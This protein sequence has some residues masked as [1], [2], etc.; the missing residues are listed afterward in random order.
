MSAARSRNAGMRSTTTAMKRD[1]A[2]SVRH[3]ALPGALPTVNT[4]A[5]VSRVRPASGPD[6]TRTRKVRTARSGKPGGGL[7]SRAMSS[8]ARMSTR[9]GIAFGATVNAPRRRNYRRAVFPTIP[10]LARSV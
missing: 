9:G 2:S 7:S 4:S 3:S 8:N 5:S 1:T 10:P 6:K